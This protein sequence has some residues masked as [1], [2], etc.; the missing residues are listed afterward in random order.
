LIKIDF[1]N[2]LPSGPG[3]FKGRRQQTEGWARRC[4]A[5]SLSRQAATHASPAFIP[6][7]GERLL[8]AALRVAT[9]GVG[10]RQ[11]A[12]LAAATRPQ[13]L[14]LQGVCRAHHPAGVARGADL[15]VAGQHLPNQG[16]SQSGH[17]PACSSQRVERLDTYVK[18]GSSFFFLGGGVGEGGREGG[19]EDRKTK[20]LK[21]SHVSFSR[22]P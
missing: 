20:R 14:Y 1:C 13:G 21:S 17:I 9:Q 6:G 12:G 10:G 16:C 19:R 4:Q 8:Q 18:V 7:G 11:L 2:C 5:A 15:E 3:V 22:M